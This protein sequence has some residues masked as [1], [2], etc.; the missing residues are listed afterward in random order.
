[1]CVPDV[2]NH[3]GFEAWLVRGRCVHQH[4]IPGLAAGAET[5]IPAIAARSCYLAI[6]TCLSQFVE[7]GTKKREASASAG[8]ATRGAQACCASSGVSSI[9]RAVRPRRGRRNLAHGRR[10]WECS[11]QEFSRAPAGRRGN[12]PPPCAPLGRVFLFCCPR[13]PLRAARFA[14]PVATLRRP[15]RGLTAMQGHGVA[16]LRA[17][18]GTDRPQTIALPVFTPAPR[19]SVAYVW[20]G[21]GVNEQETCIETRNS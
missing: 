12:R 4:G 10:P 7:L 3:G 15:L 14:S 5:L 8:T 13:V 6:D 19:K 17:G 11:K 2:R 21:S 20:Y 1:V 16:L 9:A 18:S